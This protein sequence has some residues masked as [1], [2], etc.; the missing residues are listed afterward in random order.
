MF[1]SLFGHAILHFLV[2]LTFCVFG[3]VGLTHLFG[4]RGHEKSLPLAG[5]YLH[6][7]IA[8]TC[9]PLGCVYGRQYILFV[10]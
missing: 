10:S 3:K 8:S 6:V 2:P 7:N 9:H 1:L 5:K 4:R